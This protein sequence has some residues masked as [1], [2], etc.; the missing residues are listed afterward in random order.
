MMGNVEL[1]ICDGK[2]ENGVRGSEAKFYIR[3]GIVRREM[4]IN[5]VRNVVLLVLGFTSLLLAGQQRIYIAPNGN[6]RFAGTANSPLVSL[7]AA[8]DRVRLLHQQGSSD[9]IVVIVRDGQYQLAAP[10]VLE[11]QDSGTEQA[12]VI[13]RADEGARPVFSGGQEITGFADT[14]QGVWKTMVPAVKAGEW[15]F[16]QL[17]V[18]GKRA[19]RARS[20]NQGFYRFEAVTESVLV[21]GTGRA[22]AKAR[23]TVH[24]AEFDIAPLAQLPPEEF[25]DV[26]MVV[27]H[28]WDVT[29]R[30]LER[31]DL[32]SGTLVTSGQGMKPWNPW[33]AGQR[34]VLENF[35]AALDA[36]GEWFLE[37]NGT[38]WY[39]P[40][41]GQTIENTRIIAPRLPYAVLIKGN[42]EKGAYVRHIEI[43]GLRFIYFAY[44][45]PRTGFEPSQAAASI[46][47]VV[48]ADGAREITIQECE[49]AH[50]GRYGIWL[51][52]G[53]SHCR[54]EHNRL[55]D[56]GAG[57]VRIGETVI[58][59]K[60]AEK[61][62]HIVVENNIIQAGGRVFPPAVGVWI[63]HA[64]DNVVR[65]NDIGDFYYT[66]VSV[67]WRWGYDESPAKRNK[68][69]YNHIHHLGWGVL[70][71]M[72]GV[73]TLGRSEG[74]EVSHNY[75]HHV[76][77]Y[78][79]GGWGLYTDEGSSYIRMEN[80]LV[81][82]TKTGGFHQHYGQENI[83]H[84]NIFAFNKLYQLQCTRVEDH[85][86][87]TFSNNIVYF[88]EGML[89][90]GRWT[91]I[92]AALFRNMYWN[93]KNPD[94]QFPNGSFKEWQN[95]GRDSESL[96]ADPQFVDPEHLDFH[97]QNKSVPKR[98][99]FHPF[100]YTQAGVIGDPA[101][102]SVA[103]LD[104]SRLAL[105]ERIFTYNTANPA[106]L[107]VFS[108]ENR[109]K[110]AGWQSGNWMDQHRDINRI[111]QSRSL[112][113]VFL[114]NSITQSWGGTDRHVWGPGK[115]V[116]QQYYGHRR[117]ANFGISG[118]RTQHILWR[119]EH[120]NFAHCSPKLIV[121]L[122]GTNNLHHN[123]APD[124]VEGIS[125]VTEQLHH[126]VPKATILLMGILPRGK[127][128]GTPIRKK[129]VW[130]NQRV[131][132][133][134]EK[135]FV[136]YVD[137]SP[138]FLLPDGS[139]NAQL[140]AGDFVHL[141]AAGYQRW[142]EYLEP[143][144]AEILDARH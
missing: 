93:P 53:C 20:P 71:D 40:L 23:Q 68:I 121:L 35:K 92:Q 55:D 2:M 89:F 125:V 18:N 80:N 99:E 14:G 116:W 59:E 50:T 56:L 26:L 115:A 4:M 131:A 11:P 135:P 124:I 144:I 132:T 10:I 22:P 139:A 8:R 13:Y 90:A 84:N 123:A 79:Y 37:R 60:E 100:D 48:T 9:S 12:P 81:H 52:R 3:E 137:I 88:D 108:K 117:A 76:F 19:N 122:I 70:S 54:I 73:Y 61:T 7:N 38:L 101:W 57:G 119:I 83:I 51:R 66:G 102:Q 95:S 6:D 30:F 43:R 5:G 24:V 34:Y 105:F 42:P 111:A 87:F 106:V 46:D 32:A 113:L 110:L 49:I 69:L 143:V 62:H 103:Q 129:I 58:R 94:P 78:S 126:A 130:I 45:S 27:Y 29:R 112:D 133:L 39:K 86:S 82:H 91:E 25:A 104:S 109:A 77:A 128:P 15:Y 31:M 142:A 140:M 127:L 141:Q 96:V 85:L 47:A 136:K 1:M 74:T 120:G 63:G 64:S 134:A 118:D 67:G 36:P 17:Y 98:I 107:P 41:P 114:G 65:H 75:I 138:A 72:A 44:H 28:K 16:E 33:K 97:F 21:R